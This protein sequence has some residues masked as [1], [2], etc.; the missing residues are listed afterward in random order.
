M[1]GNYLVRTRCKNI[2][3]RKFSIL[4]DP[5]LVTPAELFDYFI[6][7]KEDLIR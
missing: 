7:L 1:K 5:V 6:D 2:N 3:N 4:D